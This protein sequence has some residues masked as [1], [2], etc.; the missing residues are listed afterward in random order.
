MFKTSLNS[1]ECSVH[2]R[3]IAMQPK[4]SVLAFACALVL[5]S[6]GGGDDTSTA[7][8]TA[9]VTY[10]VTLIAYG[11]N[12]PTD[13]VNINASATWDVGQGPQSEG[14]RVVVT[15]ATPKQEVIQAPAGSTFTIGIESQAVVGMYCGITPLSGTI[16]GPITITLNCGNVPVPATEPAPTPPPAP[17]SPPP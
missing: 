17:V 4:R 14:K 3:S 12:G 1:S 11:V 13:V 6:C 7:P 9:P 8:V 15:A 16:Q 10:P 2:C 5:T